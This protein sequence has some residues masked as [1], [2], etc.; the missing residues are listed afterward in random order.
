MEEKVLLVEISSGPSQNVLASVERLSLTPPSDPINDHQQA[1]NK[2]APK[3]V[4]EDA[5]VEQQHPAALGLAVLQA[6][7][8]SS[9][10][11]FEFG[12]GQAR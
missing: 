1:I 9:A 8:S 10:I 2:A 3:D 7:E 6:Q 11:V 12:I 4:R 5:V